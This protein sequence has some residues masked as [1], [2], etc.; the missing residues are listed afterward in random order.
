MTVEEIKALLPEAE[1]YTLT[2][3]CKYLFVCD[4]R[5]TEIGQLRS[6]GKSLQEKGIHAWMVLAY[7][8]EDAIKILEVKP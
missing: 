6:L 2:P 7:G 1:V 3:E 8:P 4:P 5:Y